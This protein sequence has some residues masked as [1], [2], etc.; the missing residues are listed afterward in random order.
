MNFLLYIIFSKGFR[1]PKSLSAAS[2][3]KFYWMFDEQNTRQ[4]LFQSVL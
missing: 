3:N 2:Q 4:M 1:T